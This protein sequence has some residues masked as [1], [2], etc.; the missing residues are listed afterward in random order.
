VSWRADFALNCH[1]LGA[2]RLP[3]LLQ[4][5]VAECGTAC[6][7]M[8]ASYWGHRCD[9]PSLRRRF[10]VSLKGVTL[11]SLMSMA[12]ALSLQTRP[13][14]L[15][16]EHLPKLRL[17][18]ILHWDMNHFVVLKAI[19]PKQAVIHD[20]ASGVVRMP[21]AEVS[22]HFT[23]VA[24]ELLP[25]AN[26]QQKQETQQ[27]SL[28]SLMGQI[29]GLKR[30]LLR[31]LLLGVALQVCALLMPFYMQ[32]VVDEALVDGDRS[33]VT[34]LG[35]GALLLV[36]LQSA[37]S[38]TRSW[39]A[40]ALATNLNFQWFGNVFAHLL[41]LPLSW[42]EKRHLGDVVSRFGAV[43]TLQRGLTTQ[44]VEAIIDGLLVIGT[45]TVMCIY[46]ATLTLVALLA[47]ALYAALRFSLFRSLRTATAEQIVHAAK[48]QTQFLETVRGAQTVRLFD[49]AAERSSS[50]LNLLADQFNAELR[51]ARLSLSHQTANTLLFGC[52]R[53]AI[54]WLAALAVLDARFSVGMLFAFISYKD[55]FSQRLAALVDKSCELLMLRLHGERLADIVLTDPEPPPTQWPA[56]GAAKGTAPATIELRD[57]SFR[58]SDGE[59][60]VLQNMNLAVPAGQC[61]AITGASGCGKTTLIKLL[62]GLHQPTSGE[63]CFGGTR[64]ERLGLNHYRSLV[65]TVMQD[66]LLF[67][68]SIMDNICFFDPEPDTQRALMCAQ[69]AAIHTDIAGMPMGYN[70]LVGDTGSGLSGGQKQRLLLARALY[71]QPRVLVLDEATSHLDAGNEQLVNA[72]LRQIPLT[73]II[74]AHRVETIAMA[75]RVVVLEG[76]RIVRDWQQSAVA[77]RLDPINKYEQAQPHHIDEVPIPGHRFEGEVAR[78]REVTAQGAEPDH[79]QH[80]RAHRDVKAVEARQ[81]E[82]R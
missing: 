8:V 75:Q 7:A 59:P 27:F 12:E 61:V 74:V 64:I 34:V 37:I 66:D 57:V 60:N 23:G 82:K 40:T 25:G 44:V 41:R 49:R 43:Q 47:I 55:Q 52:E 78:G 33:L 20:P 2:R 53:I 65:G 71:K 76:G 14:K 81:H 24:L 31:L 30:G 54:I 63:I 39:M 21:M 73:R 18:C 80:D 70:T 10:S 17:P 5:E 4:S 38:A 3:L 36:V 62:L 22:R 32:W 45:A 58:Y 68:G 77:A 19:S 48:Q 28:L 9:L 42:F 50:W 56:G 67:S 13:L 79:R 16:L 15:T 46:S 29:S 6:L 72:A 1:I 35:M 26:F 11:K 69:F 51:I